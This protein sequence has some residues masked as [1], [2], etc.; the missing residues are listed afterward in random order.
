MKRMW[1]EARISFWEAVGALP[2][3]PLHRQVVDVAKRAGVTHGRHFRVDSTV[4]ETNVHYPTHSTLLQD[5]VRALTRTLH[6]GCTTLGEPLSRIRDRRRS[7][8]RRCIAIRL[9]S[10]REQSR[11]ARRA[12]SEMKRS[13][14]QT[15][16]KKRKQIRGSAGSFLHRKVA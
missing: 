5:G 10:R 11:P 8:A 12:T 14:S 2:R 9:Q 3:A 1:C 6:Q 16:R 15:A 7:V 4:V 13:V